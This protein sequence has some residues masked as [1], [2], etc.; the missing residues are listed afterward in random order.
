VYAWPIETGVTGQRVFVID[1]SGNLRGAANEG[2]RYSGLDQ[3]PAGDAL[4][5]DGQAWIPFS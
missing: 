2:N 1:Q 5:A 3:R 4:L